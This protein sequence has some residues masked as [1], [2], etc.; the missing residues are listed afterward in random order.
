MA[1]HAVSTA[2]KRVVSSLSSG[3]SFATS[4]MKRVRVTPVVSQTSSKTGAFV[5]SRAMG[6]TSTTSD[7]PKSGNVLA[8]K[9]GFT[10]EKAFAT[11][12]I[13]NPVAIEKFIYS[14]E[15]RFCE[16]IKEFH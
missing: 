15:E 12:T 16:I 7:V 1:L 2:P 8:E 9:A 10:V 4:T 6:G 14:W 5:F 13:N 3:L 11:P